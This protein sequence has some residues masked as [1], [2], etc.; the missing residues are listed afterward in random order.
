VRSELHRRSFLKG[1]AALSVGAVVARAA[2]SRP[3]TEGSKKLRKALSYS[4]IPESLPVNDRFKMAADTG[5]DGVEVTTVEDD[6]QVDT[7]KKAAD[8]S[9]VRIHSVMHGANWSHPLTSPD[10]EIARKG[11]D[12]LKRSIRNAHALGADT[13][14]LIPAVVTP[15]VRYKDAW[16]R[17]QQQVREVLPLARELGVTLA[18][19]NVGNR[20]LLSPLEFSQYVDEFKDPHIAAYFDI[21][22]SVVLWSY[23]QDWIR[24]LGPRIRKL[25]VKDY[26]NKTKR[27]AKLGEGDVDWPAVCDAIREVGYHG[28]ATAEMSGGDEKYLRDVAQRMDNV[29]STL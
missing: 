8:R 16:P 18:I 20:F 14:L 13:V 15:Q 17:S 23:P 28:F 4:M 11:L 6:R 19:E 26:D 22:N 1:A 25:H 29:F 9:G 5:F 27:W 24:T 7:M 3:S 2:Q 21:G 10:A 12:T